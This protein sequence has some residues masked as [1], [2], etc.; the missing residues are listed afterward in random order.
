MISNKIPIIPVQRG[1]PEEDN[2]E[3]PPI[4]LMDFDTPSAPVFRFSEDALKINQLDTFSSAFTA[5]GHQKLASPSIVPV[6]WHRFFEPLPQHTASF[7]RKS[8]G[9]RVNSKDN[10]TN[11]EKARALDQDLQRRQ[12]KILSALYQKKPLYDQAVREHQ[13][14]LFFAGV[15]SWSENLPSI[16]KS[17]LLL[18]AFACPL[19]NEQKPE[20]SEA[21]KRERQS[22][23]AQRK[24]VNNLPL[25]VEELPSEIAG[26]PPE[27]VLAEVAI[28]KR[29]FSLAEVMRGPDPPPLGSSGSLMLALL[30]Q[31]QRVMIWKT[32]DKYNRVA[33]WLEGHTVVRPAFIR[34][35]LNLGLPMLDPSGGSASYEAAIAAQQ[36]KR[37]A[38]K[39][40]G[41]RRDQ[42]GLAGVFADRSVHALVTPPNERAAA[43]GSQE[44]SRVGGDGGQGPRRGGRKVTASGALEGGSVTSRP[45]GVDLFP[46]N[47]PSS[48]H[49]D[50]THKQTP[51]SQQRRLEARAALSSGGDSS[52]KLMDFLEVL[53]WAG[54]MFN[55]MARRTTRRWPEKEVY[56]RHVQC[57]LLDAAGIPAPVFATLAEELTFRA[58]LIPP[59]TLSDFFSFNLKRAGHLIFPLLQL[60]EEDDRKRIEREETQKAEEQKQQQEEA[61]RLKKAKGKILEPP[62]HPARLDDSDSD[63]DELKDTKKKKKK[64]K[65][66]GERKRKVSIAAD[67]IENELSRHLKGNEHSPNL[68]PKSSRDSVFVHHR[69]LRLQER[70]DGESEVV[71]PV[72]LKEAAMG[73][74]MSVG[75]KGIF[76]RNYDDIE[77]PL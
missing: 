5:Q 10:Y 72:T 16:A 40:R 19:L 29:R 38:E 35:L 43:G 63:L 67:A 47:G 61:A 2:D 50:Q 45:R 77:D 42:K 11:A 12:R 54:R 8:S 76:S 6:L 55:R 31:A 7:P 39:R 1:D 25:V 18:E 32:V 27:I 74:K 60:L 24:T 33:G 20:E 15:A 28:Q 4:P 37:E 34:F 22:L 3:D 26:K 66:K 57:A 21:Y 56:V 68:P 64:K 14:K 53:L 46:R 36:R 65:K 52:V 58:S 70:E 13:Q 9:Y 69:R 49:R 44:R 17:G 75:L 51:L 48:S 59:Q 23:P 30:T 41:G 71:V 62:V 73:A